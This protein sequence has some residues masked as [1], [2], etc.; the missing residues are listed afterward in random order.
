MSAML[1]LLLLI[2]A[3]AG[4]FYYYRK[5]SPA[6]KQRNADEAQRIAEIAAQEKALFWGFRIVVP[7]GAVEC[8]AIKKVKDRE[9]EQ[10]KAPTLPLPGCVFSGTCRCGKV[11]LK[12][13]RVKE[14]RGI[15]DRRD[16]LRFDPN[17]TPRR[18]GIDRRKG[19]GKWEDFTGL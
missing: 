11:K 2:A 6:V 3:A 19:T 4:V 7:Q 13:R 17:S 1:G 14:R 10:D 18:S 15:P 9:F 5:H 12:E 8:D 16:G